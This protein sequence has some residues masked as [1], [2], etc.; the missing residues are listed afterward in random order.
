MIVHRPCR[1]TVVNAKGLVLLDYL[2]NDTDKPF[3]FIPL[4][5]ISLSFFLISR[6]YNKLLLGDVRTVR[7][8]IRRQRYTEQYVSYS[9]GG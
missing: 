2:F 4:Y 6:E 3:I 1:Y 7:M 9:Q 8:G 5:F